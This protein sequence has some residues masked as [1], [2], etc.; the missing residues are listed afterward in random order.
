MS[1]NQEEDL[2]EHGVLMMESIRDLLLERRSMEKWCEGVDMT[3][4]RI[5]EVGIEVVVRENVFS[6]FLISFWVGAHPLSGR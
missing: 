6:L 3:E 2:R 5:D 1:A 4:I